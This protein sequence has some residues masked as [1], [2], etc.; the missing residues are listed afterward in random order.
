MRSA[1][2]S[3]P[4]SPT[5][6]VD[7]RAGGIALGYRALLP[8]RFFFGGMFLYAGIDKLLDPQFLRSEGI[9]SI[10]E[11]LRGFIEVSPLAPLISTFALPFPVLVGFGIALL[12]IAIGLGALLGLLYRVA[13]VAGMALS[14]LFFLTASWATHPYYLGADL[15][16]AFGWMTLALAGD[17]GLLTVDSWLRRRDEAKAAAIA[18]SPYGRRRSGQQAGW[19]RGPASA[20]RQPYALEENETTR[21][22]FL[23]LGILAMASVV[24]AGFALTS[25]FRGRLTSGIGGDDAAGASPAPAS[26]GTVSL[27][28]PSPTASA[29]EASGATASP[30]ASAAPSAVA[31]APAGGTLIGN[32]DQVPAGQAASFAVPSTGDPGILVHLKSGSCVAYDALCTHEGCQVDFDSS[33]ALIFCPCHGAVFDPADKAKVLRG[34]ARRPLPAVPITVDKA[35]NIYVEA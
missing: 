21:R 25:P 35:G 27:A 3:A 18:A 32:V 30:A 31:S 23:E 4:A 24:V 29:A 5:G 12:E 10:G 33:Q 6:R 15:P 9:G 11:Q 7:G 22:R 20:G 17:G 2:P 14:F 26:S 34:P 8:M 28:T 19:Q 1:P 16:Y 13:A